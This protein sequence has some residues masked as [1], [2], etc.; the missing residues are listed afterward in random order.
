LGGR[1]FLGWQLVQKM[2]MKPETARIPIIICTAAQR[3]VQEQEGWLA[4]NGVTV[5]LKPFDLEELERAVDR[6]LRLAEMNG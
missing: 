5:V 4:K 6:S 3:E 1:E 2:R